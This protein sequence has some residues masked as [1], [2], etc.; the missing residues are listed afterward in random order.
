MEQ[1]K[2]RTLADV[3]GHSLQY[4]TTHHDLVRRQAEA[5]KRAKLGAGSQAEGQPIKS[6]QEWHGDNFVKQTDALA[7]G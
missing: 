3:K 5:K 2:F 1:H 7:R 4:F 6:D